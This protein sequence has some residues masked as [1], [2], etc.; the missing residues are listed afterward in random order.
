MALVSCHYEAERSEAVAIAKSLE[1]NEITTSCATPRNDMC[2]PEALAEGSQEKIPQHL[3]AT[4]TDTGSHNSY[5]VGSL[6]KVR[7][8]KSHFPRPTGEGLR[9]RGLSAHD[10][11]KEL[12]V[13][14]SYRLNDFKK[15]A[16]TTHVDMS[17]NIRRVAFTL[18]EVLITLGIIGIVAT[19]TIPTLL[20]NYQKKVTA[21]RLKT[22][23]SK[24]MQVLNYVSGVWFEKLSG[25]FF[26]RKFKNC[27]R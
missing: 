3:T 6:C 2:H 16:G 14:T 25:C 23:Y 15:K 5:L 21:T 27:M 11:R 26:K 20:A 1:L 10:D 22:S 24:M 13:L 12:N 4:P 19:M 8:D 17:G 9:E 7:D 18:A